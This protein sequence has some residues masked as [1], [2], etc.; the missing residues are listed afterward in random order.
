[1]KDLH[2]KWQRLV[3]G[4]ETCPR[5][6]ATGAETQKA[7]GVLTSRLAAFGIRVTLEIVELDLA[8]FQADPSQSN[9][10]WLAGKPLE[11]WLAAGV[12]HSACCVVCGEE[13]CRT[14]ELEGKTYETIPAVL[15]VQAGI[16]AASRL[17]NPPG[18]CGCVGPASCPPSAR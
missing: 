4:S 3:H 12:G 14:L 1:M 16:M 8:S 15:I 13:E 6:A 10:L 17:L 11:D 18:P 5:C 2:I 9:R 7:V